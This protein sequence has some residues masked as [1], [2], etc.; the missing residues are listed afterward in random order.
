MYK[1]L[2]I[3]CET[4]GNDPLEVI[5][6][7]AVARDGIRDPWTVAVN[8]RFKPEHPITF[9][10]MVVHNIVPE[11]LTECRPSSEAKL[12]ECKYIIGHNVDYDWQ[13]VG[14]PAVKRICTLALSRHLWPASDCHKLAAV[15]YMLWGR[16][17]QDLV[18]RCHSAFDDVRLTIRVL[19]EILTVTQ[20]ESWECLWIISETA[21]VPKIMPFGKHKGTPIEDVPRDYKAWLMQQ[22]DVDPYLMQALRGN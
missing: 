2:I 13:A 9:G 15:A 5:E 10:A 6:L 4:T 18:S 8:E 7:A 12:P 3:D 17:V 22:S 19:D 11:D 14:S 1:A 20:C 21:R 16:D